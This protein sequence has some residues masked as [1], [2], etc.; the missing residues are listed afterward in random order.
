MFYLIPVVSSARQ[1]SDWLA[2]IT[3]EAKNGTPAETIPASQFFE[4]AVSRE[5]TAEEWLKDSDAVLINNDDIGYFGHRDFQCSGSK[6]PYL[7]RAEYMNGGTGN[8]MV[9]RFGAALLVAHGSLGPSSVTRRSAL[10]VCLDFRPT[11]VFGELS[12]AM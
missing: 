5:A 10:V 1:P 6:F 3:L 9:K 11:E 8:F 4:I 7:V 2:P 12:G